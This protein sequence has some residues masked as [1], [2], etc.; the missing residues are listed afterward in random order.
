MKKRLFLLVALISFS[1]FAQTEPKSEKERNM[2]V[3]LGCSIGQGDFQ[4]NSY[5]SLE[6]GYVR[7][8]IAYGA[9]L[10]R[11]S[12]KNAFAKE[13]TL[14][15]YYWEGKVAP[16]YKLGP[17]TGSIFAGGGAYFNSDHYFAEL[18]VGLSY[19]VGNYSFG[20]SFS[21]WDTLNYVTPSVSYSF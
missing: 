18:G 13:D 10:G 8:K 3:S 20:A 17:L 6:V 16:F 1:A 19:R 11:G 21:N 14:G 12:F 2:Y 7:E 5:P 15:F 4:T 9:I